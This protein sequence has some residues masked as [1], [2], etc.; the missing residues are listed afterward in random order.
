MP[1]LMIR[2]GND[3][4]EL[5][6][7]QDYSLKLALESV[8]G[9]SQ[10]ASVGGFVK[11]VPGNHRSEPPFLPSIIPITKVLEIIR[12]SNRDVEGRVL[13][14][15]G[16]EYMVRGPWIHQEPQGFLNMSPWVL[17]TQERRST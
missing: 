17:I 5:R 1:S 15:S 12:K 7:I 14:M 2:A 3:L 6:S 8:P 4:S 9:V 10:V 11:Q 13:E 16:V